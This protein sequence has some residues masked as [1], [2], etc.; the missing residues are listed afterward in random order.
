MDTL[1]FAKFFDV[2]GS[3]VTIR[4][5]EL[6]AILHNE[7]MAESN[8]GRA[9]EALLVAGQNVTDPIYVS[10]PMAARMTI[11]AMLKT[12]VANINSVKPKAAP[13]VE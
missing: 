4:A 9:L 3:T 8:V 1:D 2:A 11:P 6:L 7:M 10:A 13:D 5:K 12:V